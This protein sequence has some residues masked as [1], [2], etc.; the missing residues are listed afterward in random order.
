MTKYF[1]TYGTSISGCQLNFKLEY[2]YW[3]Q[4]E[5]ELFHLLWIK[6]EQ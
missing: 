5:R 1:T 3:K 2:L 4:E 6:S